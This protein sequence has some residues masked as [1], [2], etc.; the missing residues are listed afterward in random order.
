MKTEMPTMASFPVPMYVNVETSRVFI[1]FISEWMIM[2]M[3]RKI[4]DI[5]P[6]AEMYRS[7]LISFGNVRGS[8][9]M[10]HTTLTSTRIPLSLCKNDETLSSPTKNGVMR[11]RIEIT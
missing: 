4:T 5:T 9:P 11:S 3:T 2:Q 7:E 6:K 1:P 8:M 10:S